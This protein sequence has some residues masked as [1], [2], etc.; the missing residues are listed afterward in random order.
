MRGGGGR[1]EAT[2]PLTIDD[3]RRAGSWLLRRLMSVL[4]KQGNFDP[5]IHVLLPNG[6]FVTVPFNPDWMNSGRH[7]EALFGTVRA[8][9]HRTKAT[10]VIMATDGF[11]V[12]YSEQEKRRIQEDPDYGER[13]EQAARSMESIDDLVA[14][15]FGRKVETILVTVQ[16]PTH[17]M[18]IQQIYT[19]R[20]ADHRH[21]T[22]GEQ[23]CIDSSM[24]GR[25]AG[26]MAIWDKEEPPT[27]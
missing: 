8:L 17:M 18:L 10:A 4:E 1:Q 24:G 27:V 22:F 25:M 14:A 26:R 2:N 20:G 12:E 19:R 5:S 16:T 21:I 6:E 23:Q 15:G 9:A 13:Y 7:K 11:A 3:I